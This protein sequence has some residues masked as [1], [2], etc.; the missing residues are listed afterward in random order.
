MHKMNTIQNREQLRAE[1]HRLKD[2]KNTQEALI[3]NDWHYIRSIISPVWSIG[4]LLTQVIFNRTSPGI[5]SRLISFLLQQ[6]K[7][8]TVFG[9]RFSTYLE[10]LMQ[11]F[12]RKP[13]N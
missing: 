9:S 2:L 12:Q 13:S 5:W 7:E 11:F 4:N 3:V 6:L 8:R 1:I 10:L